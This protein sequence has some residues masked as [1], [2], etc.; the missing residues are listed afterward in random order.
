MNHLKRVMGIV[1]GL[2]CVLAVAGLSSYCFKLDVVWYAG[3][4]KPA[5]LLSHGW[6]VLFV[7]LIYLSSVL[8]VSNLIEYK[9]FFPSMI[10]YAVL[11]VFTVLF[12]FV[13]ARLKNLILSLIC[14]TA[15]LAM[16][17]ILF[18]RFLTKNVKIALVYSPSLIFNIYA[19]LCI[20][21]LFILN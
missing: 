3:L 6:F 7:A 21:N 8:A 1:A 14:M 13:F 16:S 10:F 19:F 12:C 11:G 2:F 5:F 17:Y 9:H 20:L 18:I 15:V 4:I